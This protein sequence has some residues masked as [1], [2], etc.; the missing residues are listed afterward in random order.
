[1]QC[2]RSQTLILP[3]CSEKCQERAEP[4]CIRSSRASQP[5]IADGFD[6]QGTPTWK[7]LMEMFS[8][9]RAKIVTTPLVQP[10]KAH[11]HQGL[12]A[13]NSI[14]RDSSFHIR[15]LFKQDKKDIHVV[16][17]QTRKEQHHTNRGHIPMDTVAGRNPLVPFS[18]APFLCWD[19][20]IP[21]SRVLIWNQAKWEVELICRIMFCHCKTLGKKAALNLQPLQAPPMLSSLAVLMDL[22]MAMLLPWSRWTPSPSRTC[23]QAGLRQTSRCGMCCKALSL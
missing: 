14:R 5:Q 21:S 22:G 13:L 3:S 9:V 4:C 1:M 11:S 20:T 8:G 15:W 18:K 7:P 10:P 17:I 6:H 23:V 12:V 2:F 19:N 16:A